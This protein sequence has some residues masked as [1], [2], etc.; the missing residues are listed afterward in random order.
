MLLASALALFG[1]QHDDESAQASIDVD[2][3]RALSATYEED[4]LLFDARQRLIESCMSSRGFAMPRLDFG[5]PSRYATGDKRWGLPESDLD[6]ARQYGYHLPPNPALE[7]SG[8]R[9]ETETKFLAGLSA[10]QRDRYWEALTD[11]P[12]DG[13]T[14]P[15]RPIRIGSSQLVIEVNNSFGPDACAV[16][17]D[18]KLFGSRDQYLA[19]A[20]AIQ[21]LRSDIDRRAVA[22]EA[23]QGMI[24]SWSE[25]FAGSGYEAA[26]P[27]LANDRFIAPGDAPNAEEI[28]AAVADI[29]CKR[30]LDF[31][32]G[33]NEAVERAI[34]S[35][36]E[37][38]A[39][40]V[41]VWLQL[42]AH[43]LSE[44]ASL[45]TTD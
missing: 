11:E 21:Q 34:S 38:L 4:K 8:A 39:A 30:K 10:D 28:G 26:D 43:A 3:I 5:P 40:A 13:S 42:K 15:S 6:S 29:G 14:R 25:C 23:V 44:A 16:Q 22:D 24:A 37:E 1:C 33:W 32:R 41:P 31:E 19:T 20:N 12:V 9:A 36:D 17:A 2:G 45:A 18:D 27:L 7:A 35:Y